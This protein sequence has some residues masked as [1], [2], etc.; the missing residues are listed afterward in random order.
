QLTEA[1]RRRPACVV[2]LD[3]I[4]KAHRDTQQL[5]LQVLDEGH[6]TDGRGRRVDFTSSI[7]V[8]T[9]NLGAEAFATK[10]E[11]A[12]GFGAQPTERREERV[13]KALA[14]AREGFPIELWNRI[15]DR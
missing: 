6:L 10:K 3:E 12:V 8:L 9:S 1:V 14:M 4:E 5:I 7:V 15:E 11:R 2:L 13:P